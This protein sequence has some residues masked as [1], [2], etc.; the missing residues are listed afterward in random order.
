MTVIIIKCKYMGFPL[1]SSVKV[2]FI[3]HDKY[4]NY[5]RLFI[6]RLTEHVFLFLRLQGFNKINYLF[7]KKKT[8]I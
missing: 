2:I 1:L 7:E 8:I 4:N 3:S 6:K 5:T